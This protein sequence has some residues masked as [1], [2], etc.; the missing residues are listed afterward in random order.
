MPSFLVPGSLGTRDQT[1]ALAVSSEIFTVP[2]R[3]H[4]LELLKQETQIPQ[5]GTWDD[6]IW[7]T[8]IL[9]ICSQIVYLFDTENCIILVDLPCMLH[10]R[11][12]NLILTLW[13]L[14]RIVCIKTRR[15]NGQVH[16]AIPP[17]AVEWVTCVQYNVCEVLCQWISLYW[18][19]VYKLNRI[20]INLYIKLRRIDNN[21]ESS[22]P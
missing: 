7:V 4:S 20:I 2:L 11:G 17:F 14:S 21:N 22:K 10:H 3:L 12:Q 15:Y 5:G 8:C 1:A 13:L 19:Y 9:G 16:T 6:S 18:W